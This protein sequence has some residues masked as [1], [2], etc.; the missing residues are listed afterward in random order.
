M[1][2]QKPAIQNSWYINKEAR[3]QI[4]IAPANVIPAAVFDLFN[5]SVEQM[6]YANVAIATQDPPGKK[7]LKTQTEEVHPPKNTSIGTARF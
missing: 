2:Q 6:P 5:P 1:M 4:P 3:P 7:R